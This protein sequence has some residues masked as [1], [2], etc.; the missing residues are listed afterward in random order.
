MKTHSKLYRL[1]IILLWVSFAS[2]SSKSDEAQNNGNVNTTENLNGIYF[3]IYQIWVPG[4]AYT[5]PDYS[6]QQLILV[7][8]AGTG[9]L[10]GGIQ[11]NSDKTYVWNS[12]WDEKVIKGTWIETGDQGY[13]IE[14]IKAQEGKSWKIGK[15]TDTNADIT[16]WDGYIWYDGKKIK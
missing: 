1:I 12:S 14:L 11:I 15:S 10:P 2:C 3:G 6:N 7:T 5:I 4:A 13:P 9:V 16:I 8:S